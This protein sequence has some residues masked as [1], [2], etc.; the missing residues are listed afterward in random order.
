MLAQ[1][2]LFVNKKCEFGKREV[3]YLGHVISE[4]GVAMD[5]EKI[6]AVLEWEIPKNLRELRGFLGLTGYYHKVVANYAHI[7]RPLTEQLKEDSFK[8]SPTATE[9]FNQLKSAMVSAPVLAMPNFQ[10]TFVVET[11]ALGY[12]MGAVLMQ[13]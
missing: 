7:A 12:G 5:N 6:Q 11:D 4:D 3:A 2:E 8:W 10:L 1:H 9:A 13:A